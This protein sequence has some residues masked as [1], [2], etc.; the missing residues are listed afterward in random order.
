MTN[1][2]LLIRLRYA[3]DIKNTDMVEIFKLG[4][5]N[6][7]KEDVLKILTKRKEE[8]MKIIMWEIMT[9]ISHVIMKC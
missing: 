5:V 9:I 6:V 1:N 2:D 8:R 7:T 4:G 3:L